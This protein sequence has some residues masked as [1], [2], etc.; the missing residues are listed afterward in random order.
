MHKSLGEKNIVPNPFIQMIEV[1]IKLKK[2]G[3]A[4]TG[5]ENSNSGERHETE[6]KSLM[7]TDHPH[8]NL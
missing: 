1:K 2:N 6:S 8:P 7:I 4:C 5:L 3:K